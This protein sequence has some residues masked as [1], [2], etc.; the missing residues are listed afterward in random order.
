M[1][2]NEINFVCPHCLHSGRTL[3]RQENLLDTSKTCYIIMMIIFLLILAPVGL[4]MLILLYNKKVLRVSHICRS[5]EKEIGFKI[6][7]N[8]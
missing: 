7:K 3:L 8:N 4:C 1:P 5:C 6:I 2:L